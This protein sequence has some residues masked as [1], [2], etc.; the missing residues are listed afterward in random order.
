MLKSRR[1][2][3]ASLGGFGS[4][5]MEFGAL[6]GPCFGFLLFLEFVKGFFAAHAELSYDAGM[7]FLGSVRSRRTDLCQ[8][9]C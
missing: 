2:K 9:S 6:T 5:H 3:I 8:V 1:E 4:V 7:C